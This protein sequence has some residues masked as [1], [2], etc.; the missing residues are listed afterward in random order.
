MLMPAVRP[1]EQFASVRDF[2]IKAA[3]DHGHKTAFSIWDGTAWN[4]INFIELK[5]RAF[6]TAKALRRAGVK[7]GT[8]A[9]FLGENSIEWVTHFFGVLLNGGVIVPLDVKLTETELR[10][11][12]HHAE[13]KIILA[14]PNMLPAA[15]RLRAGFSEECKVLQF[16]TRHPSWPG[17]PELPE[18][19]LTRQSL[20]V[21]CYT[22]GTLGNPKGVRV[23]VDTLL[24][25]SEA[26]SRIDTRKHLGAVMFCM[27]PMTH[28]Y[29]LTAGMIYSIVCGYEMCF[30]HALEAE[31]ILKCLVERKVTQVITVP[32]FL[33]V[34]KQ[35]IERKVRE[36][37]KW[38][39][40]NFMLKLCSVLPIPWLRKKLFKQIHD[41]YGGNLRRFVVGG[42]SLDPAIFDFYNAMELPV[43]EGYGLT[44]TGP[45]ITVNSEESRRRGTVGKPLPGVEVRIAFEKHGDE[46]GEIQT[47]GPHVMEGYHKDK[48]LTAEVTTKDGW[49][50][51]GDLGFIDKGG[52]LHVT[53]RAKALIVLQSGKKV[54]PEEV[55]AALG[56]STRIKDVCVLGLAAQAGSMM[57]ET[58]VAVVQP[59]EE[60]LRTTN[61][62][63]LEASLK[64]EVQQLA[65]KLVDFKRPT[66]IVI[67]DK[68]FV[69]TSTQKVKRDTLIRELTTK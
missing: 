66:R 60:I 15:R 62:A 42:S 49:F 55:E 30:A 68:P 26:V 40:F 12:V 52:F 50:R 14:S 47:R 4:T 57:G 29:G 56:G 11:I 69:L 20:G 38:P 51:T 44:E 45:I 43:F 65:L 61:F 64:A 58:V 8:I 36:Q 48:A 19:A 24:F 2:L 22:S 25:E 54:H 18:P 27:V 28:L 16:Q 13:P 5:E 53:G 32:L 41:R 35:A 37:G 21:I 1:L 34:I 6:E 17:L 67:R 46:T 33:K 10:N 7:P 3:Q 59:T 9:V 23:R 39:V 63:E 31:Q